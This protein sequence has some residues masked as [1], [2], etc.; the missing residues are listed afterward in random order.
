M[1]TVGFLELYKVLKKLRL[2]RFNGKLWLGNSDEVFELF[3]LK[4]Q[5]VYVQTNVKHRGFPAF[6]LKVNAAS[7]EQILKALRM[8]EQ[9][10][11]PFNKIIARYIGENRTSELLKSYHMTLLAY[12]FTLESLRLKFEEGGLLPEGIE[13]D[14]PLDVRMAFFNCILALHDEQRL[15]RIVGSL[16]DREL[17]LDLKK[18]N[19]W[20]PLIEQE[21]GSHEI[22]NYLIKQRKGFKLVGY[23]FTDPIALKIITIFYMD[24]VLQLYVEE[25]HKSVDDEFISMLVDRLSTMTEQSYYEMLGVDIEAPIS[26]IKS[27]YLFM[28]RKFVPS[29]FEG[30]TDPQRMHELIEKIQEVL[31][32]AVDTLVDRE[33]RLAYNKRIGVDSPNVTSKIEAMFDA[34]KVFEKGLRSMEAGS[35]RDARSYFNQAIELYGDDPLFLVYIVKLDILENR[36]KEEYAQ[37]RKTLGSIMSMNP[38]LVEGLYTMAVLES[39]ASN[40]Q[41]AMSYLK[42]VFAIDP[43]YQDAKAMLKILQKG[44][45]AILFIDGSKIIWDDIIRELIG[46]AK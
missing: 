28:K 37:L 34:Y 1:D 14:N 40:R 43:E 23:A 10:H 24:D 27:K 46:G 30:T 20:K 2:K 22:L 16:K 4:G 42:R 6:L 5:V 3:F 45:G 8:S 44:K 29:R 17:T 18:F 38:E 39:R 12:I 41:A 32:E 15:K 19:A 33:R 7:K 25:P 26:L 11:V 9:S 35:F 21:L 31:K 13:T 36:D